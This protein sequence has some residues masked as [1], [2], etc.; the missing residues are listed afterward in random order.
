MLELFE[1][2]NKIS[3]NKFDC[4]MGKKFDFQSL[5]RISKFHKSITIY[6]YFLNVL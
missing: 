4:Q 1:N 6:M 2:L 3:S 5:C